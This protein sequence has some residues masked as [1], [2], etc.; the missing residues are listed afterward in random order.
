MRKENNMATVFKLVYVMSL[1][2]FLFF[3]A[4]KICG[5]KFIYLFVKISFFDS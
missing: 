4:E 3:V 1:L 5:G 2:C